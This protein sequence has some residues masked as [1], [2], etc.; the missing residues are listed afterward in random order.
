MEELVDQKRETQWHRKALKAPRP[1]MSFFTSSLVINETISL[2][3]ARGYFSAAVSFLQEVGRNPEVQIV[4]VDPVLQGV[5][6]DLFSRWGSTGANAVDCASFAVME[7]FGIRKAFSF[8]ERFRAAGF[9]T[10]H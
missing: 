1:G 4:H 9:E 2:L 7:K 3:Q 8:D 6:W 5:A 10:L